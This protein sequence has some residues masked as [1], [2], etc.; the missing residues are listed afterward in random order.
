MWGGWLLEE[1][2]WVT[3]VVCGF[4]HAGKD[5]GAGVSERVYGFGIF[6]TPFWR[7]L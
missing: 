5:S 1:W 6:K 7:V 4:K 3:R 2:A